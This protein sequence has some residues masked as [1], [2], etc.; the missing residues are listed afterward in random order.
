MSTR[1]PAAQADIIAAATI[2]DRLNVSV[3]DLPVSRRERPPAPTFTEYV[4]IVYPTATGLA[5]LINIVPQS[6]VH[7][8]YRSR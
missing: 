8:Q 2:L 7:P 3:D 1:V 4:P 5:Q 6:T